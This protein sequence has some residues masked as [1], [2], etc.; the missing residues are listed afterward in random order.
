M[1]QILDQLKQLNLGLG[2]NLNSGS[3]EAESKQ[4]N[5]HSE[6]LDVI[7]A[8]LPADGWISFQSKVEQFIN[9]S[10]LTTIDEETGLILQA[11][12]VQTTDNR[13]SLHIRQTGSGGWIA[14]HIT[15]VDGKDS[16]TG[17]L[18]SNHFITMPDENNT[19]EGLLHYQT[20]WKP[21]KNGEGYQK[22]CSRLLK[23]D[24]DNIES[25]QQEANNDSV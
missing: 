6:L 4:K 12:L 8:F 3:L 23:L 1:K 7:E 20:Y 11:E 17:I 16:E 2:K 25:K 21:N 14:N 18:E 24:I 5:N 19:T 13:K 10:K 22:I 9:L 15:Q